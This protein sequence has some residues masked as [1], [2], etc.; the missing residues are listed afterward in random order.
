[1]E[2][3][4]LTKWKDVE[5]LCSKVLSDGSVM[6]LAELKRHQKSLTG[7]EINECHKPTIILVRDA[8]QYLYQLI[9][10][11]TPWYTSNSFYVALFTVIT[12]AIVA[13]FFG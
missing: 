10:D 2:Q 7:L 11:K 3:F 1:M 13:M 5:K 6:S 12:S 8:T 4:D 9:K